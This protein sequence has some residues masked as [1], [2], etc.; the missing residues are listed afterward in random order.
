MRRVDLTGKKFGKLTV[1]N[2][3]DVDKYGQSEWLCEC[4]C[5]NKIVAKMGNLR[6]G[7]TTSCGC[8]KYERFS[9]DLTGKQ[10]GRLTVLGFDHMGSKGRAYW[11]CK[12]QC[13][14]VITVRQDELKSDHTTSCGCY[15]IDVKRERCTKH[16]L[17]NEKLY[18]V[19]RGM[20]HRCNSAN[21]KR[22]GGRGISVCDEWN[23]FKMFYD[24]AV[25]NGYKPG[26][27]IDRINND[28]DYRPENCRWADDITQANNKCTNR[29]V[30][31]NGIVHTVSEWAR[32]FGVNRESL[33]YR[34]KHDNMRDFEEYF[35]GR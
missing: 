22:Y 15:A 21:Y 5:G 9:E 4:E 11:C 10:F 20:R 23:N 34:I 17:S 30:E 7:H 2:F 19:W 3:Y 27:T 8:R 26:L 24:W 1:L 31:Y 14:E 12:C 13:G 35:G 29:R 16:G 6:R 25:D 28:G 18:S 32:I 33:S